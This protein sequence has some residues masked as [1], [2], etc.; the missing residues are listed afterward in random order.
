[1]TRPSCICSA[2]C[3]ASTTRTA[4][5]AAFSVN[6]S[7]ALAAAT[8]ERGG[9]R[10]AHRASGRVA[11]G[12]RR[13]P[14]RAQERQPGSRRARPTAGRAVHL[15]VP[16]APAHARR[17]GHRRRTAVPRGRRGHVRPGRPRHLHGA[18]AWRLARPAL[19]RP[20]EEL[21]A[22]L[23][24]FQPAEIIAEAL[25]GRSER[26]IELVRSTLGPYQR[27]RLR[28]ARLRASSAESTA[29]R[30]VR[31]PRCPPL[32]GRG[33]VSRPTADSQGGLGLW[34]GCRPGL[35]SG[36]VVGGIVLAR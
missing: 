8:A 24:E 5:T 33:G 34:G 16:G 18:F 28:V 10:R 19:A 13:P 17:R 22:D 27:V 15:V 12:P 25:A 36:L 29:A 7:S 11:S 23:L 30:I 26:E 6:A 1:M 35:A 14:R 3:S 31:A 21:A 32:V 2:Y 20:R 4:L 9:T